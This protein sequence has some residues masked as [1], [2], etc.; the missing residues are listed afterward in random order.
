MTVQEKA[1][2]EITRE[3]IEVLSKE[4]GIANTIRFI[5]QFTMGYGDYTQE[6][7]RIFEDMTLDEIV[8]EIKKVRIQ[9]KL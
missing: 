4:I 2:S 6:R 7:E 9:S 3:A 5:N 1:L 8:N